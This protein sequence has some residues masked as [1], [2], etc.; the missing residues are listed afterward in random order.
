MSNNTEGNKLIIKNTLL[1]YG[2]LFLAM[3]VALFISRVEDYGIC[4]VVGSVVGIIGVL[5]GS[6]AV[7]TSRFITFELG[8]KEKNNDNSIL[9]TTFYTTFT[10]HL[11]LALPWSSF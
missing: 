9:K 10:V 1:L 6:L 4:G 3:A 8:K 11:K 5:N 7:S 2:R